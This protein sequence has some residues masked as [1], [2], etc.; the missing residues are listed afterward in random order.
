MG[1]DNWNWRAFGR[2]DGGAVWKPWSG[3]SQLSTRVTPLRT[4]TNGGCGT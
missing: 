1:R 2:R 3:N 4:S